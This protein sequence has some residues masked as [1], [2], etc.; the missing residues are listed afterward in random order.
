MWFNFN[1]LKDLGIAKVIGMG[2]LSSTA[3]FE[4]KTE[5]S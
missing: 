5:E 3:Y 2:L 4:L 1:G